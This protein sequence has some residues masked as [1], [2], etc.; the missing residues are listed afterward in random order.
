MS[1]IARDLPA[2][3]L[4]RC[5]D[6]ERY[7]GGRVY[8]RHV[9]IWDETGE[10]ART[11]GVITLCAACGTDADAADFAIDAPKME[12]DSSGC[13]ERV[14]YCHDDTASPPPFCSSCGCGTINHKPFHV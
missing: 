8:D 6:C 11:H 10:V 13:R 14:C 9:A 5:S 4:I 7:A 3:T 2:S 1:S 12:R